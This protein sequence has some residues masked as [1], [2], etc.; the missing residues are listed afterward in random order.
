MLFSSMGY[1]YR[2]KKKK[3]KPVLTCVLKEDYNS[4]QKKH[5]ER[6]DFC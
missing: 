3:E 5:V 2:A 1:F 6:K 4:A